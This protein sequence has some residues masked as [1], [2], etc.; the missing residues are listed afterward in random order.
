MHLV[1]VGS[2]RLPG[3]FRLRLDVALVSKPRQTPGQGS[4]LS[5]LF[6][7]HRFSIRSDRTSKDFIRKLTSCQF[8]FPAHHPYSLPPPLFPPHG[9][10]VHVLYSAGRGFL[11]FEVRQSWKE[12]TYPVLRLDVLRLSGTMTASVLF[13][14]LKTGIFPPCRQWFEID[15]FF[16]SGT[17]TT[18]KRR[19][20]PLCYGC[21]IAW[22]HATT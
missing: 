22:I 10:R 6:G 21:L 2:Y 19:S 1:D 17:L 3:Y 20:T 16:R 15:D 14:R 7:S 9:C 5:T 18:G 11:K 13:A 12:S 8:S 4:S